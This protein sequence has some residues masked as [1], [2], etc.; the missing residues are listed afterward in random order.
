MFQGVFIM[1]K[2]AESHMNKL[3][4]KGSLSWQIEKVSAGGGFCQ[5]ADIIY[6]IQIIYDDKIVK[7]WVRQEVKHI[8]HRLNAAIALVSTKS[9]VGKKEVA[10]EPVNPQRL[11]DNFFPIYPIFF[12]LP[13]ANG[14]TVQTMKN[15]QRKYNEEFIQRVI[16]DHHGNDKTFEGC[17]KE[18]VEAVLP[19]VHSHAIG[20]QIQSK[21][22]QKFNFS[23]RSDCNPFGFFEGYQDGDTM[24]GKILELYTDVNNRK[25]R[26]AQ[27]M[28]ASILGTCFF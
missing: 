23:P 27:T 5:H 6:L 7:Y 12:L 19:I 9:K 13:A 10:Y 1:L 28:L 16:T 21:L 8:F 22:L 14:R 3:H 17:A 24:T 11:Y 15:R 25:G 2:D 18:F 4:K 26:L 20:S